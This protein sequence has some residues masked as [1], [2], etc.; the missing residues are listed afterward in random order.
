MHKVIFIC[1]L[2]G[3]SFPA[4]KL[5]GNTK[6]VMSEKLAGTEAGRTVQ[7]LLERYV[8]MSVNFMTKVGGESPVL[9]F[10]GT[11][12]QV[13]VPDIAK[14]IDYLNSP[15]EGHKGLKLAE[16]EVKLRDVQPLGEYDESQP[17]PE[18]V[19]FYM[20]NA[21]EAY[22]YGPG[23]M[24][25]IFSKPLREAHPYGRVLVE[26]KDD[27]GNRFWDV[28]IELKR[29]PEDGSLQETEPIVV[30]LRPA[31]FDIIIETDLHHPVSP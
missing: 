12:E 9:H 5:Y 7:L 14:S 20:T 2:L 25:S 10:S 13:I 26:R 1:A 24:Q 29:N 16:L 31:E 27:N 23:H 6:V 8:G 15:H 3:A 28:L 11:I 30:V 19:G 17:L 22:L 18:I 4:A 21:Y